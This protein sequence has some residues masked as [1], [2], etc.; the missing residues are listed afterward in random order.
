MRVIVGGR[1]CLLYST[2]TADL[3]ED[4]MRGKGKQLSGLQASEFRE[5]VLKHMRIEYLQRILHPLSLLI[6]ELW[7]LMDWG[8]GV[9]GLDLT[10]VSPCPP[11][12]IPLLL[13]AHP[14]YPT[15][16]LEESETRKLRGREYVFLSFEF[17]SYTFCCTNKLCN[18]SYN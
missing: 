7:G 18:Q 8:E 12:F 14:C 2:S 10:P 17:F 13:G 15:R 6:L 9:G 16:S 11:I 4:L 1:I 3:F 5:K